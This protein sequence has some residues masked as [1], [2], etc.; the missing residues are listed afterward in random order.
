M[1]SGVI[2]NTLLEHTIQHNIQHT[3]GTQGVRALCL[4]ANNSE[5]VSGGSDGVLIM[6]DITGGM[7][8]RVVKTV[9]VSAQGCPW[10]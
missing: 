1:A 2:F 6:W 9:Q 8:G 3:V 7:L 4:R 5:L 10:L